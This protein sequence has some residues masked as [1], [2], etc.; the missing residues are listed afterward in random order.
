MYY[1]NKI[2]RKRKELGKNYLMVRGS[3]VV[4]AV[5]MVAQ[6]VVETVRE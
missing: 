3:A 2:V 5:V 1:V 4:M 6:K